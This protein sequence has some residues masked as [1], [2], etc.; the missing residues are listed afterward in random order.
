MTDSSE[1]NFNNVPVA[2]CL[3]SLASN[4]QPEHYLSQSLRK[5]EQ[6]FALEKIDVSKIVIS[7][8]K[9]F[10]KCSLTYHNQ[11]AILYFDQPILLNKLNYCLK[12]IEQISDRKKFKKPV[13]TLDID[14][15]AFGVVKDKSKKIN[16]NIFSMSSQLR[17]YTWYK[18]TRRFP[19]AEYEVLGLENL[20]KRNKI[21]HS[22]LM[23]FL[24]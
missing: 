3:L 22:F 16:A 14:I 15:I 9:F 2:A 19:L 12:Q 24:E 13:V 20:F 11:M 8:D 1:N 17:R 7:P 6:N 5:F 4:Y 23:S 21:S 18:I 10:N